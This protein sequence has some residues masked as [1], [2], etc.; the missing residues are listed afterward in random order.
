M[1]RLRLAT[2]ALDGAVCTQG[3]IPFPPGQV[4]DVLG[5]LEGELPRIVPLMRSFRIIG[6]DDRVM[7]TH[8]TSVLGC[9]AYFDVRLRDRFLLMQSRCV[10]VGVAVSPE[11]AGTRLMLVFWMPRPRQARARAAFATLLAARSRVLIERLD[12]RLRT[13]G[14]GRGQVSGP[15][16]AEDA[17]GTKQP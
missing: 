3:H 7:R 8:A 17:P 4:W 5:D 15:G 6:I 9:R 2:A 16:P 12:R 14:P 1:L 10:A 11:R 13:G